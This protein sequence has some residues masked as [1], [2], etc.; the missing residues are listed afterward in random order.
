VNSGSGLAVT[1]GCKTS[2]Q[3]YR[4]LGWEARAVKSGPGEASVF[5]TEA[6]VRPS[7]PACRDLTLI[8]LTQRLRE[9]TSPWTLE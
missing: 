3:Q 5:F 9:R 4:I 2:A 6:A 8:A 7:R 1:R